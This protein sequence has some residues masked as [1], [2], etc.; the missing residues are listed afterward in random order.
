MSANVTKKV[1]AVGKFESKLK[2]KECS[3]PSLLPRQGTWSLCFPSR[4]STR[5]GHVN[6]SCFR[7]RD[8][9]D[10]G[11]RRRNVTL[12]ERGEKPFKRGSFIPRPVDS[13][14]IT[15]L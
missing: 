10:K 7:L 3:C 8:Y 11:P 1:G 4:G 13:G 5:H 15:E 2:D 6:R 9:T 12:D 14:D